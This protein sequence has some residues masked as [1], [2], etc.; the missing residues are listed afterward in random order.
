M[1]HRWSHRRPLD[2][3][4][5]LSHPRYGLIRGSVRDISIGG[6]FVETGRVEFPLNT[7]VVVSFQLHNG[8]Q[9]DHYRLH[10]IVVRASNEGA[11]LMYLDSSADT[12]RPL[13]QMLYG[14]PAEAVDVLPVW[15]NVDSTITADVTGQPH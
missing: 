8:N 1:E 12:V 13:R 11:A 4:V 7:P 10:A 2:G 9:S 6:M 5:T 14:P 3:E 15:P